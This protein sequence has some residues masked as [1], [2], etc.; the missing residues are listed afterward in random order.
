MTMSKLQGEISATAA[1]NTLLEARIL[2]HDVKGRCSNKVLRNRLKG[3]VTQIDNIIDNIQYNDHILSW[4]HQEDK[5][6]SD[7]FGS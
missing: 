7:M 4:N 6:Q 5:L 3:I 1:A 2:I